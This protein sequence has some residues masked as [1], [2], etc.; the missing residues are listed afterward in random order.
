MAKKIAVVGGNGFLGH[1]VVENLV[2]KKYD[3]LAVYNNSKDKLDDIENKIQIEEFLSQKVKAVSHIIFAAGSFRNSAE[4]NARLNCEVLYPISKLYWDSRLIYISSTSVY[5]FH[6]A[7]ITEDSPFKSPNLYGLANLA[8]ESI[9][10]PLQRYGIV[11][12]AYLYGPGLDNGSYIPMTLNQAKNGKIK[13]I[14][15]GERKQDYLHV[16]DAA[17]LCSSLL[18]YPE[19]DIFLGATGTSVSNREVAG[20]IANQYKCEIEY[21]KKEEKSPSFFFDPSET[22]KKLDWTPEKEFADGIKGLMQ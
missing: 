18:E 3:I 9:V 22:C 13:V 21:V 8:G 15:E 19:N 1:K 12:L 14:D 4:E 5:G 11:R 17:E 6:D 2:Q 10:M 20:K 16:D 7:V